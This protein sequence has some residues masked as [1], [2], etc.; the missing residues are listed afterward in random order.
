MRYTTVASSGF[1]EFK[2]Y[3]S[4]ADRENDTS[5]QF[6]GSRTPASNATNLQFLTMANLRP[7]NGFTMTGY[8][9]DILLALG[10][11]P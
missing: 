8:F 2:G 11:P 5:V 9:K 1:W 6:S 7:T 3:L 10:S 4:S